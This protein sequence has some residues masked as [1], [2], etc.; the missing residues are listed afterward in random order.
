MGKL[1]K[2]H[3]NMTVTISR[4]MGG[5]TVSQ[6]YVNEKSELVVTQ[7]R[8]AIVAEYSCIVLNEFGSKTF[9]YELNLRTGVD[10]YFIYSLFVSLISMIVPSIIGLIICCICEYQVEKNYPLTPPCYPTPLA[11]TPPNFDFNE[12]MANAASYLPNINIHDTLD[13]VSKKLRKGKMT[14]CYLKKVNIL[15]IDQVRANTKI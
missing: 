15:L 1:T 11:Q 12:W 7:M 10:E 6:I 9:E 2:I 13:Q 3:Q 4:Y 5:Q 8:Q 14:I